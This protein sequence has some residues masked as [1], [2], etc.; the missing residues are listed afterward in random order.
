MIFDGNFSLNNVVVEVSNNV[1]TPIEVPFAR[2]K[3]PGEHDA[4][5]N[6]VAA[7]VDDL[8]SRK[9]IHDVAVH[10]HRGIIGECE[11]MALLANHSWI[12]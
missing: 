8:I 2:I 5:T 9:C 11:I 6:L 10:H 12:Q 7:L 4:G 1:P 3:V